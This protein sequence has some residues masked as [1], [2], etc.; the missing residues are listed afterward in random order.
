MRQLELLKLV[1]TMQFVNENHFG[2]NTIFRRNTNDGVVADEFQAALSSLD[3]PVTRYPAGEP[4]IAYEYGLTLGDELPSHLTNYLNFARE[5]GEK[6]VIVTPTHSAYNGPEE[7]Y[8][9]VSMLMYDYDDVVHAF[10]VGNEYWNHQTETSYGRVANDTVIAIDGALEEFDISVPIWVQMASAGGKASEFHITNDE[11]SWVARNVDANHAILSQLSSEAREKIDGVVEHYYFRNPNQFLGQENTN[12]QLIGLDHDLW[13]QVLGRELTLNITEWNI[14]TT[15]LE[16]LGIR[17]GSALVT[18][19]TYLMQLE[20]D[21]A[22][23]WPPQ[24]NTTSDLAG[25]DDVMIDPDTGI[26]VNSVGGAMFDLMSSSL[27]GLEYLHSAVTED[28]SN[29]MHAVYSNQKQA[30]VYLSSRSHEIETI[31][32]SPGSLLGHTNLLSATQVG[33]DQSSSDG[34]HWSPQERSFVDS[35]FIWVKGQKY[36][37]NEHDVNAKVQ[38]LDIASAKTTNGIELTLN[39]Y[40]V[41]ELVYSI[42]TEISGGDGADVIQGATGADYVYAHGGNDVIQTG[43][44]ND[45]IFAGNGADFINSGNHSD[46]IYGQEGN[47]SIR[48]WGGGDTIFGGSGHDDLDGS[49]G[50]DLIDGG[51]G[52]DHLRGGSGNDTLRDGVGIDFLEGGDGDDRIELTSNNLFVDGYGALNVSSQFQVG[53]HVFLPIDGLL[54]Y[55][56]VIHGGDGWDSLILSDESDA[57]FLDDSLS[58]HYQGPESIGLETGPVARFDSIEEFWAGGGDDVIDFT[59]HQY[60][61]SGAS[62]FTYGEVGNDTIWGS[63][64]DDQIY[65]GEGDDL[66]FGGSGVNSLTGGLGADT[67]E[68]TSSSI[69]TVVE[70]FDPNQGDKIVIHQEANFSLLSWLNSGGSFKLETNLGAIEIRPGSEAVMD[71][72]GNYFSSQLF[73]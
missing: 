42:S 13:Q 50:N 62:I 73:L 34:Q 24:H 56:A 16:Q 45:T 40:E 19:F 53:T 14:R 57:F 1:S 3:I 71:E 43:S 38:A 68:F 61:V 55:Q 49:F 29:I 31:E 27:V 33:Y 26:V 28:S 35:Q 60:S 12:D 47:D 46:L 9:F 8:D 32:F 70:D 66:L 67:F 36:Y 72:I 41:V 63:D 59:S 18:Q 2:G 11:G 48:G 51:A 65:G 21:E 37:I 64:A 7:V 44:G 10:E 39:P 5:R 58:Q 15:N 22:Y 23:V 54:Q 52:N 17:A 69:E 4:D 6:V 30:V 20:V 25:A